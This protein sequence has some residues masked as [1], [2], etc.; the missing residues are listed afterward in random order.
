MSCFGSVTCTVCGCAVEACF[1][2]VDCF[3]VCLYSVT[4]G[5]IDS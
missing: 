3:D 1:S 4:F 5:L 2:G